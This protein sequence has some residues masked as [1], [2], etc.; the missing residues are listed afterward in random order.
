MT[1][2]LGGTF[3]P[4]H[5]GHLSA[6]TQLKSRAGLDEV[7]LMPNAQP[8][9]RARP[10]LAPAADRLRMVQLAVAALEGISASSL[11]VERGGVSYTIDTVRQLRHNE[12]LRAFTL[13]LGSDAALQI[14]TWHA[15]ETLLDEASFTI[16][17]RPDVS[18]EAGELERLGFPPRRTQLV[19]LRTPPI[20]ARMVRERLAQGRPVDAFLVPAVATYIHERGLYLPANRM[21]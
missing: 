7:W 5:R 19:T 2:I 16:F 10:P 11:E 1:G 15:C 18:M 8:P 21:G 4:V 14:R 20:S 6:A 9:H 12:P 13:L 17:S 3:D